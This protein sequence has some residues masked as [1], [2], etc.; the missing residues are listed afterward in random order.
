MMFVIWG[1]ILCF[2]ANLILLCKTVSTEMSTGNIKENN[3]SV[4]KVRPMRE[5]DNL[6]V[7]Y[8]PIV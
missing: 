4:S 6:T 3:V 1:N 8:E 5:T 7:I 2:R